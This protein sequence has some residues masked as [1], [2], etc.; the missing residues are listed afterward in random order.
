MGIR[1]APRPTHSGG[2]LMMDPQIT[3]DPSTLSPVE[4]KLRGPLEEQLTSALQAA[5]TKI[6]E[7]YAGQPVDVVER[8]LFEQTKAGLHPDIAAAFTPDHAQ[9]RQVAQAIVSGARSS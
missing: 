6:S 1:V 5:T 2:F 9:L 8:M 7:G 4:E 3:L